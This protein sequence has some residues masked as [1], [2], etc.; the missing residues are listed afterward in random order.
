MGKR[1]FSP[2]GQ[3]LVASGGA[4]I[5]LVKPIYNDG[6]PDLKMTCQHS[7]QR[8]FSLIELAIALTIIALVLV[9]FMGASGGFI[10]ARRGEVTATKLKVIESAI[11]LYVAQN[12][13]LPCPADGSIAMG[14]NFSGVEQIIS[15]DCTGNQA[16][17]VVPAL[18]LGMT[19]ADVTDG[20]NNRITYRVFSGVDGS[21]TRDGAMDMSR[22]DPAGSAAA[23][24]VNKLCRSGCTPSTLST[25]C[26][27]PTSFLQGKGLEVRDAAG[28]KLMDPATSTGAA[29]VLISHGENMGGA[30]STSGIL[31]SANG[32]QIGTEESKN[33]NG[34]NLKL[35]SGGGY[36]YDSSLVG[37]D[38]TN[39]FDDIV[40]R[41]SIMMVVNKAQL[42]P[43]A[44][45]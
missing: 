19:E 10:N 8:G 36:Y 38:T 24:G 18:T 39:H 44:Y 40:V 11:A 15:G 23:D 28:N 32:P 14:A 43:R 41:P 13:R 7:R 12:K 27:A 21:L 16:N 1:Q 45:Y 4:R 31:Q 6:M 2:K 25:N 42:G 17:G 9:L 3:A 34:Q 30:Y 5:S 35:S 37:S 20:W 33:N 29:Y 26:V 22:C